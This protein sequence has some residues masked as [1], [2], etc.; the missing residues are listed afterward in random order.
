MSFGAGAMTATS[1]W[2]EQVEA[3]GNVRFRD[4]QFDID[5]VKLL[6]GEYFV[7]RDNLMLV[8]LLGS[9]VS[10]CIRDPLLGIG[11]MNH[12]M[13]PDSEQSGGAGSA[14]YGSYAME[15]LI[16]ELIKLGATR[17]RLEAKVFGG[18]NVLKGFT[19]ANVGARNIEFVRSYLAAER[20]TTIAEDLGDTCPR[21]IH[22]FPAS[23]R[24]MV[25]RLAAIHSGELSQE[26]AYSTRLQ[27][28]PVS[29]G[30]ELF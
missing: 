4:R 8:T 18:G 12:F 23:G 26:Q 30:V 3:G 27:K 14:R 25:K 28:Q 16:N 15:V 11:G 2:D 7:T 10:A 19:V 24:A 22:Y 6:P 17:K 13:L 29:G 21:K 9:C 5:A 1:T 20:I